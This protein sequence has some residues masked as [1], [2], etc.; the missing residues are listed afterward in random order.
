MVNLKT[1]CWEKGMRTERLAILCLIAMSGSAQAGESSATQLAKALAPFEGLLTNGLIGLLVV[2]IGLL[3]WEFAEHRRASRSS[4]DIA[5][6]AAA[7]A[8]KKSSASAPA[9]GSL[10]S[11]EA[12][13]SRSFAPPPPPPPSSA[14]PPPSQGSGAPPPPPAAADNPFASPAAAP[15]PPG[16]DA[17]P[18]AIPD[19]GIQ[20]PDSTV[21][22][23]PPDAGSSGGW[24]D[25][26]QRVRA[27]EP[28]AA[29]F[30]DSSPAPSTES[31]PNAGSPFGGQMPGAGP[32]PVPNNAPTAGAFPA[33]PAGPPAMGGFNSP[34][35]GGSPGADPA[36]AAAPDGS[37]SSEAWEALLKRTTGGPGDAPAESPPPSQDSGRISLGSSFAAPGITPSPEPTNPLGDAP[38]FSLPGGN[39]SGESPGFQLPGGAASNAPTTAFQAGDSG[40]FQI[41]GTA[42]S[43][44]PTA[45]FQL[46]GGGPEPGGAPAFKLPG[47]QDTGGADSSGGAGFSL[48]GQGGAN[49]F[50][51]AGIDDP[52]ST[53]PL[54]D[55]FKSSPG[56]GQPSFQLPSVGQPGGAGGPMDFGGMNFDGEAGRTISLDFSQGVGQTPPPPQ[57]KTEG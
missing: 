48:P 49:P 50:E 4:L 2:F 14:P 26:L 20:A 15:P 8:K 23:T 53:L 16:A 30:S 44:A 27:G 57:P 47:G 55:M 1:Q 11:V 37:A 21:A 33:E 6:L 36:A 35:M 22:F 46:G 41:P 42:G 5:K 39:D 40:G 25:L 34:P 32:P 7:A 10:S 31:E 29:S 52:S 28:E 45:A 19:M 24:A 54:T 43:N 9:S 13:S 56:G 18:S 51:G 38:A 17:Q 3:G 12:P